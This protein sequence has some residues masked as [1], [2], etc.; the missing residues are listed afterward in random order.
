MGCSGSKAS[1][2]KEPSPK[3][4]QG[5]EATVTENAVEAGNIEQEGDEFNKLQL[6]EHNRVRALHG[7]APL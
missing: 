2:G 4:P 7:A 6:D 1:K 5:G 3:V